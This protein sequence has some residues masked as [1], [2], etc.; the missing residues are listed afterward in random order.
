MRA[1][2]GE[3]EIAALA[4]DLAAQL[5]GVDP[6]RVVGAIER[7]GV[8]LGGGLDV[9]ADAAVPEQLDR[10]QQ[11]RPDQLVR[12]ELLGFDGERAAR[13]AATA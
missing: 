13:L 2:L 3:P 6:D 9:G 5:L 4:D 10:C 1:A 12:R 11:D 7:L 8:A